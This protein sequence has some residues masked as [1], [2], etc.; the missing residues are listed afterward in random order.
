LFRRRRPHAAAGGTARAS[1]AVT[2]RAAARPHTTG[3][4]LAHLAARLTAR[5]LWL[6]EL[7]EEHRMLTTHQLTDLAFPNLDTAQHRLAILHRLEVLERFRPR[8]DTGSAPFHYVLGPAGARVFLPQL[9][10]R[11]RR[12]RHPGAARAGAGASGERLRGALDPDG[13]RR[14]PGLAADRRA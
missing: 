8:R 11:L 10:R 3:E 2:P 5:D 7:L 6:C 12:R 14:V 1:G 9:R 4:R 13:A